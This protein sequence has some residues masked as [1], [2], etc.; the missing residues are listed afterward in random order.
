MKRLIL[1]RHAK[2]DWSDLDATDHERTLNERGR[3]SATVMGEWMRTH[4]LLPDHV[5]CSDA[6]RTQETLARLRFGDVPTTYTH[7]LYLAEPDVMLRL[8]R[9][10]TEDCVMLI[11][12]NPGSAMLAEMLV[13]KAPPHPDFDRFPTGATAVLDFEIDSWR[14]LTTGRGACPLFEVPRALM[15]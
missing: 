3:Q 11:G 15:Q 7:S 14:D 6:A 1:I 2:S 8:L 9:K 5:L 4:D 10:R 12:H 13:A